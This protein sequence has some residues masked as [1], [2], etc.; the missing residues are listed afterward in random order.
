MNIQL[1]RSEI[2]R[3]AG[4]REKFKIIPEIEEKIDKLI[5]E[6]SSKARPRHVYGIYDINICD[7]VVSFANINLKSKFL[8]KNLDKCEKIVLIAVTLGADID[9]MIRRYSSLDSTSMVLT[10]AIA[11]EYLEKYLD[12]VEKNIISSFEETVYLKP[13]FS[14][15]YSDLDISHQKDIVSILNTGKSIGLY[16][17]SSYML[18][19]TKSVTAI[20]GITK[21]DY[22]KKNKCTMCS[23]SNCAMREN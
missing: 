19:P 4:Y 5:G 18:T 23:S 22:K 20:I 10:Q 11:A 1:D 6:L 13:R 21:E 12:E 7:D 17:T 15:G 8:V 2:R 16:T 3:Y 9:S 14:P